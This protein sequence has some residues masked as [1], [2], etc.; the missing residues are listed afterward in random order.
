[1]QMNVKR[2]TGFSVKLGN[3]NF[4]KEMVENK[5]WKIHCGVKKQFKRL[6]TITQ[7]IEQNK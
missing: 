3:Y 7:A 1:M 2:D 4:T 5:Q 6:S